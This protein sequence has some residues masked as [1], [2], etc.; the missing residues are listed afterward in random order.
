[1]SEIPLTANVYFV[2]PVTPLRS[3]DATIFYFPCVAL[4]ELKQDGEELELDIITQC[5]FI[6]EEGFTE[7]ELSQLKW[8][9]RL[10]I[11]ANVN[12]CELADLMFQ[13]GN[14]WHVASI[15]LVSRDNATFEDTDI[16]LPLNIDL[17]QR[18]IAAGK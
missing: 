7:E 8:G 12:E 11:N 17:P 4:D 9:D 18:E 5:W 16:Q 6:A 14:G 10:V 2:G 15:E 13:E 3:D 1:M